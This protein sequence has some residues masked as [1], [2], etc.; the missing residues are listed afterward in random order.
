MRI[1]KQENP[2]V[3]KIEAI[4]TGHGN[5]DKGCGAKLVINENDIFVT[6]HF[7]SVCETEF[8]FSFRC[9]KCGKLTDVPKKNIPREVRKNAMREYKKEHTI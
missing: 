4:C 3:W 2:N 8:F 5:D 6:A 7:G 1:F 9:P